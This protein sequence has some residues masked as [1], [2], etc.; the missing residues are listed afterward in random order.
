MII[1]R[2]VKVILFISVVLFAVAFFKVRQFP[3][4]KDVLKQLYRNPVQIKTNKAPFKIRTGEITYTITPLYSYELYGMVVSYHHSA[5]WWDCYHRLRW[6]DFINQK[7]IAVIWGKNIATEVYKDM[8]FKSTTWTC[9]YQW[10]NSEV[11]SR[12]T[13][14]CLSNN[15]L[16]SND[17]E[18]E[19]Q[20]M[21]A[22]RSD[23][24][25]LKGYLATYSH[26]RGEGS[27]QRGTST[28]R[29]DRGQGACE[30]IYLTD[31]KILKRSSPL[32]RDIKTY[33]KYSIIICLVFLMVLFF[34]YPPGVS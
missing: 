20:L 14:N 32:W 34:K 16:L 25:Y 23:Q 5:S 19:K 13:E 3:D 17:K 21:A 31:F 7:D 28:T 9:Y 24:I 4:K 29:L 18:I 8:R 33:A 27:F 2:I 10:P 22:E 11:R 6:K 12:F 30:T 26:G 1:K 15:H